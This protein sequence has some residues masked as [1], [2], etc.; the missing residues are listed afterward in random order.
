[1]FDT[2]LG[3]YAATFPSTRSGHF[4]PPHRRDGRRP[5]Q[6]RKLTSEARF[7]AMAERLS[8]AVDGFAGAAGDFVLSWELEPTDE[9]PVITTQPRGKRSPWEPTCLSPW[10]L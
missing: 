2:L 6:V 1:V 9:L 8:I 3:V 5:G 4:Q 10:R 7:H